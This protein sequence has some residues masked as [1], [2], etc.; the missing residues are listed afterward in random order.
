MSFDVT[1]IGSEEMPNYAK[2]SFVQTDL[3]VHEAWGQ[4]ATSNPQAA[5][6]LHLMVARMDKQS[7]LVASRETLAEIARCSVST[8]KRSIKILKEGNWL[9]VTQ[10]GKGGM[11]AYAINSR[12]AWR[13]ERRKLYT[14]AVF[15]ANVIA[16]SRE[17]DY[18][19]DEDEE[20]APL[21]RIPTL[22]S[23]EIQIPQGRGIEPPVQAQ[24]PG[25]ENTPPVLLVSE[26]IDQATGEISFV[27]R[28]KGV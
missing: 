18:I 15:T 19:P 23:G 1:R 16:S 28:L 5:A 8:V 25:L 4:L 20:V 17:Q 12:V 2:T 3:A 9:D 26:T 13:D 10:L 11:N 14:H 21:R 27:K 6:L 7:S 22:Y 24:L